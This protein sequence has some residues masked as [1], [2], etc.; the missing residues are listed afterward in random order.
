MPNPKELANCGS[1]FKNPT[2]ELQ[3]F[4]NL[5]IKYPKI[6]GYKIDEKKVKVAAGWLI[7][8][9]GLKGFQIETLEFINFRHL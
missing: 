4:K 5:K 7:D 8:N 9:L 2:I 6:I 3:D 1:F